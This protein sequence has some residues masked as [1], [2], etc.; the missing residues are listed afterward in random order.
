M[1]EYTFLLEKGYIT[2][3][4]GVYELGIV[5]IQPGETRKSLK[6]LHI[7]SRMKYL[8]KILT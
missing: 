2:K 6:N 3:K 4:N 8:M 7:K 1:D 5:A